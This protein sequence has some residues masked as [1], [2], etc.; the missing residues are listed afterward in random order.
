MDNDEP[1]TGISVS[2]TSKDTPNIHKQSCFPTSVQTLI[3]K[4]KLYNKE[5]TTTNI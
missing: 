2:L 5:Y 3:H 4:M 1:V